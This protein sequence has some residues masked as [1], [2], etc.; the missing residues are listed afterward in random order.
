M[1]CKCLLRKVQVAASA[2]ERVDEGVL[3]LFCAQV[4]DCF[5]ALGPCLGLQFAV[6]VL[7]SHQGLGTANSDSATSGV[8]SWFAHSAMAAS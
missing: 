7:D 1:L 2:D 3:D 4:S 5:G 8:S 6:K